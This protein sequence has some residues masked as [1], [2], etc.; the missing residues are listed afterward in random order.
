MIQIKEAELKLDD[1]C[2]LREKVDI[3]LVEIE[4]NE[5]RFASLENPVQKV[6]RELEIKEI[7]HEKNVRAF[8]LKKKELESTVRANALKVGSK[9]IKIEPHQRDQTPFKARSCAAIC[10]VDN[11]SSGKL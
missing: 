5:R 11:A 6:F 7:E 9:K 10:S 1:V 3:S 4:R 8:E 2:L